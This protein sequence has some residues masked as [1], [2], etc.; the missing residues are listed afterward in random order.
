MNLYLCTKRKVKSIKT[1]GNVPSLRT[2]SSKAHGPVPSGEV[3]PTCELQ[4]SNVR[5]SAWICWAWVR[6]QPFVGAARFP[7][8]V[9][10]VFRAAG[11]RW[12]G[13]DAA[14]A[15]HLARAGLLTAVL[16]S[17]GSRPDQAH[18][19][20]FGETPA[21]DSARLLPA[22]Y[23]AITCTGTVRR[24][25]ALNAWSVRGQPSAVCRGVDYFAAST[26]PRGVMLRHRDVGGM[27]TD[28]HILDC[29]RARKRLAAGTA[30]RRWA[31]KAG[32]SRCLLGRHASARPNG[33]VAEL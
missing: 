24:A 25:R 10:S 30:A 11:W 32:R 12:V 3:G 21:K 13:P 1:M 18:E 7:G 8:P 22:R 27:S 26:H 29:G 15:V 20:A 33:T 28:G 17:R 19:R 23:G 2:A 6:D 5:S 31:P 9:W 14:R 16:R 4:E